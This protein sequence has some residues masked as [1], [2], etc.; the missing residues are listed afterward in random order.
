MSGSTFCSVNTE[1]INASNYLDEFKNKPLRTGSS[2]K[3]QSCLPN[4]GTGFSPAEYDST[5]AVRQSAID[6]W[7]AV[8]I[9]NW[10]ARA[11]TASELNENDNDPA[12]KFTDKSN[13]LRASIEREYCFYY[14]RY[15]WILTS[16]LN[17]AVVGTTGTAYNK[18]KDDAQMLNKKLNEI[19]QL[20]QALANSRMASLNSYY[21]KGTG[22]NKLNSDLDTLREQLMDHSTKLRDKALEQNVQSAMIDYSLEKN[23]SSRNLLGIYGFM[24][25][26]AIGLLFYLYRSSKN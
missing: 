24:N 11:L 10:D 12:K 2:I 16:V 17:D 20:L 5:L 7:V 1:T 21:G 3:E 9:R 18:K 25:I 19:L 13:D 6:N 23:S 4:G 26:V 15:T 8:T 14:K 22:L